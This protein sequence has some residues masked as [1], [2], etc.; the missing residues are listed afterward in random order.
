M[1][2]LHVHE[3]LL[4]VWHYIAADETSEIR[5]KP[6]S[7]EES[8]SLECVV[9]WA[10]CG[11]EGGRGGGQEQAHASHFRGA[12]GLKELLELLGGALLQNGLQ[13]VV[14]PPLLELL[15]PC[16]FNAL[17]PTQNIAFTIP[18]PGF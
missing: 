13:D 17:L 9:G 12:V 1:H 15:N 3:A 16:R 11:H 4:H 5:R 7:N 8:I 18:R 10:Y 6:D 14:G 2:R